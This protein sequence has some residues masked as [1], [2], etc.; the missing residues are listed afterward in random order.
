MCNKLI[1]TSLENNYVFNKKYLEQYHI[2]SLL[3]SLIHKFNVHIPNERDFRLIDCCF[4]YIIEGFQRSGGRNNVDFSFESILLAHHYCKNKKI[5]IL[6]EKFI[7]NNLHYLELKVDANAVDFYLL[8]Y[9]NS[10][11][12]SSKLGIKVNIPCMVID[13]ITRLRSSSGILFDTYHGEQGIPDLS[14]HCRNLQILTNCFKIAGD[15]SLNLLLEKAFTITKRIMSPDG[16]ICFYGRTPDLIYGNVALLNAITLMFGKSSFEEWNEFFNYFSCSFINNK[17]SYLR[18]SPCSDN[19]EKKRLGFDSYV[20]PVV[21][22]WF[23]LSKLFC[24]NIEI[25]KNQKNNLSLSI[26][27]ET[28]LD[29]ESGFFSYIN[30]NNQITV[31]LFGHPEAPI[32]KF[33]NRYLPLVPLSHTS[34]SFF[35]AIPFEASVKYPNDSLLTKLKRKYNTKKL[36]SKYNKRNTGYLGIICI[37]NVELIPAQLKILKHSSNVIYLVVHKYYYLTAKKEYLG[38]TSNNLFKTF[39]NINYDENFKINYCFNKRVSFKYTYRFKHFDQVKLFD[40]NLVINSKSLIRF[41]HPIVFSHSKDVDVNTPCGPI[42]VNYLVSQNNVEEIS[43]EF[44]N[45]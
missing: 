17:S 35:T 34:K 12:V 14:Y 45:D 2:S 39:I 38:P 41:S 8:R 37:G 3:L 5:L 32:R 6:I 36:V 24:A 20:Y 25:N 19:D 27:K 28:H 42:K 15:N 33:D 26:R 18:I 31:N 22:K 23:A 29:L 10:L 21:Y 40:N 4:D 30:K 13:V 44:N 7:L 1:N 9:F 43:I 11:Y 16:R